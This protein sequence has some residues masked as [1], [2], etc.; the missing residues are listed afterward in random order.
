MKKLTVEQINKELEPRGFSIVS[1]WINIRTPA[2]FKCSKDHQWKAYLNNIRKGSGCP[3]CSGKA[4]LTIEQINQQLASR[5]IKLISPYVSAKSQAVFKC[6]EG[7]IWT[8]S[9]DKVK[10]TGRSCPTCVATSYLYIFYSSHLGTKIGTS[11]SPD[12]RLLEVKK[13]SNIKDLSIYGIYSCKESAYT[14][15]NRAHRFF[16]T[17]QL[18]RKSIFD[19]STEFFNIQP[20]EAEEYLLSQ[21]AIKCQEIM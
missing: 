2:I 4:K 8:S 17:K 12:R 1:E 20:E 19:G 16:S 18:F 3:H 5:G 10:N 14:L 11:N 7:H 15:E 21:G 6:I 9:V 13:D